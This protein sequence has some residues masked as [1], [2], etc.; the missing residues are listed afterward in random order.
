MPPTRWP[1]RSRLEPGV[2]AGPGR[3]VAGASPCCP[4]IRAKQGLDP[5]SQPRKTS[6]R[7]SRRLAALAALAAL[8]DRGHRVERWILVRKVTPVQLGPA[9]AAQL[10]Y[11]RRP[12]RR[13][14]AGVLSAAFRRAKKNS[15]LHRP[16]RLAASP[17]SAL[18]TRERFLNQPCV[19]SPGVRIWRC[20][21]R[22]MGDSCF[23]PRRSW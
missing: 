9:G 7:Q 17:N 22:P 18:F 8:A 16:C 23:E 20:H 11:W 5:A 10:I 2:P 15:P 21:F 3:G 12:A 14:P 1:A 13:R 6:P 4:Q 19:A